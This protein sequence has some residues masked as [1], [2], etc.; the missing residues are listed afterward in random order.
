MKTI[1]KIIFALLIN[2]VAV[3]GQ[4]TTPIIKANFG[5][6]G[7]LRSNYFNGLVQ[8]G[9]DDWFWLPGTIGTGQFIVDTTGAAALLANYAANPDSRKLP[10]YRQ[11]RFPPYSVI[12]N[13]LLVDAYF[14]RDY[15]GDDSTI[16]ASG[17]NKNGMNPS[18]WSC[19]VSQSIPDKN[20]ILD[21]ML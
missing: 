2:G 15:H 19:P 12:N 11:M 4:I 1:F 21:M 9:N 20:E 16:F 17:S 13:R 7:D 10:F 14:V 5:V 8:S 18:N 3:N 6:D